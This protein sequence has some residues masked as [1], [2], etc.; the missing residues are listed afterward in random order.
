MTALFKRIISRTFLVLRDAWLVVGVTLA[1]VLLLEMAYRAQAYLRRREPAQRASLLPGPPSPFDTMPWARDYLADAPKEES[2]VWSPY[3]YFRNPTFTGTAISVDSLGHRLT[4]SAGAENARAVR[5]FFFGGS[6]TFGWFHRDAHTI[7]AEI[8]R[9]LQAALGAGA[10][11]EPTNFGVPGYTFTQEVIA[12]ILQLQSGARPD[13]VVF[14]DGINDVHATTQN[15][16]AGIPQNEVNRVADFARG[17]QLIADNEPGLR[18]DLR[19]AARAMGG[20]LQRS[21]LVQRVQRSAESAAPEL[22]SA[23]SAVASLVRVYAENVRVVEALAAAYGFKGVYVW[24]PA[25]LS[26]AKPLSTREKWLTSTVE[27]DPPIRL[28]RDIHRAVPPRLVSAVRPIVGARFIDATP[29]FASDSTDVYAD[30]FGHHFERVNPEIARAIVP[31]LVRAA[32]F[33]AMPPSRR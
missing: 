1:L 9:Q 17:R 5:V 8:T 3:V 19:F 11:V 24:Q 7:P 26:S 18:N 25:L 30:L 15:G 28:M 4:P 33:P 21:Q 22:V 29:L 23:D 14:Y 13:A 2:L 6:T 12:L 10:R 27:T 31:A 20:A 16:R 32:I